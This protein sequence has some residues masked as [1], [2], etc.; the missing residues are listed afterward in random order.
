MDSEDLSKENG[1]KVL[2]GTLVLNLFKERE[3]ERE[4]RGIGR[5]REKGY[6]MRLGNGIGILPV[7]VKWR[8]NIYRV[9]MS[10]V[11]SRVQ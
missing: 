4:N 7:E 5:A 9:Q 1:T 3:R 6:R 10:G 2:V 11:R 8:E